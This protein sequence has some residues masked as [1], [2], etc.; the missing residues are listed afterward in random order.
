[1]PDPI[2]N[3]TNLYQ[4]VVIDHA[5]TT[6][7]YQQ[8]VNAVIKG[9]EEGL[10]P[11]NYSLPSIN[12]LSYE[13]EIS[14]DTGVRAYRDLKNLGIINSVPGKGYFI[15]AAN[16]PKR[17]K[18]C[19]FFNKLSPHKKIIYDSFVAALGNSASI[20]FYIYNNDFALF[21]EI[22]QSKKEGY[23]YY[24]IIP[25]FLEGGDNVRELINTIPG[26]KLIL[27]DKLLPDIDGAYGA[28]YESFE[29]DIYGALVQALEPLSKY[30]T[31]KMIFPDNTYYPKEIMNGF[32]RFCQE[33]AFHYNI[34][35]DLADE[36]ITEGVVYISVMEDNLV[37][38]IEKIL[39]AR[40][41]LGRQVGVIS[42]NETPIKRIILNG[43]TTISTDF[44]MMGEKAAYLISQKSAEHIAIPFQLTLRASL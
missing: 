15:S 38:L 43:I 10:L 26:E 40:M 13:L 14:R 23:S 7:K 41:E 11:Q 34:I 21:K 35:S 31:I 36:N 6:P 8:V 29:T 22:L 39:N 16:I 1:M 32:V 2:L 18:V 19:L 24:V 37:L 17:V 44:K 3:V 4:V 33:Y 20:D 28:V 9:V 12:D 42:Y 25:H 27:M 30:H 5:S